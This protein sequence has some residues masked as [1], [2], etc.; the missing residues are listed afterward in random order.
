MFTVQCSITFLCFCVSWWT[1]C[2]KGKMAR[3]GL[4]FH[5]Y[6]YHNKTDKA[7]HQTGQA[8]RAKG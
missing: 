2:S 8:K 4:F 5:H 1:V 3:K 7:R 6:H